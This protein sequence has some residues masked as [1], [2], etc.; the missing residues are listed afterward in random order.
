MAIHR[1]RA[2]AA[3]LWLLVTQGSCFAAPVLCRSCGAYIG[4]TADVVDRASDQA[5]GDVR[6]TDFAGGDGEA[7]RL[8]RFR[9]PQ[10]QEF[11]VVPLRSYQGVTA[12]GPPTPEASFFP[13]YAWSMASCARC[14]AHVGWEF[15]DRR[16]PRKGGSQAP[17][18]GVLPGPPLPASASAESALEGM[19]GA[20]LDYSQG[21]WSYRWC[22]KGEI[23]QFHKE[24]D[25]STTLDWSLGDYDPSSQEGCAR[26]SGTHRFLGSSEPLL[27][28]PHFHE[29]GQV[30][31]PP[32]LSA[33]TRPPPAH[34]PHTQRCDEH[35]KARGTEVQFFCCASEQTGVQ[36]R[37]GVPAMWAGGP[38]PALINPPPPFPGA[39]GL[40]I[41]EVVEPN[42][43]RYIVR[44]CVPD[45]CKHPAYVPRSLKQYVVP[46]PGALSV[47]LAWGDRAA[48]DPT[49]AARRRLGAQFKGAETHHQAATA[50]GGG[51]GSP[52]AGA[53]TAT[54]SPKRFLGAI[55]DK[56]VVET[57]EDLEWVHGLRPVTAL[58]Q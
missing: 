22:F 38:S 19:R 15:S 7:R 27:F 57:S 41:R 39:Q 4:D 29:G 16:A 36:V 43:C 20:C 14:K 50:T 49:H 30:R 45:L 47:W 51:H 10:G 8:Q 1:G 56:V 5:V 37:H 6:T 54:A 46:R 31:S 48:L 18:S 9:N 13:P 33:R 3:S 52:G 35:G 26:G 21:F 53:G 42:T 25:G 23:R 12:V 55:A 32:P 58:A 40:A 28:H 11:G 44:I 24:R 17:G 34:R 2:L